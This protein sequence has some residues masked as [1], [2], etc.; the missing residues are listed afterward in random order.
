MQ[1]GAE[2]H[3]QHVKFVNILLDERSTIQ[4]NQLSLLTLLTLITSVWSLP[5]S[6]SYN[7]SLSLDA[8][9]NF[10]QNACNAGPGIEK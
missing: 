8:A 10:F 3:V 1:E 6:L 4:N 7:S 2:N 5:A 9:T